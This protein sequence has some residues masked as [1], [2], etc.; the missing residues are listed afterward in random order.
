MTKAPNKRLK[1]HESKLH[2]DKRFKRQHRL[3]DVFVALA[4]AHDAKETYFWNLMGDPRHEE[5]EVWRAIGM[6]SAEK[7]MEVLQ[8]AGW[9]KST[10]EWNPRAF[11]ASLRKHQYCKTGRMLPFRISREFCS[12]TYYLQMGN[13]RSTCSTVQMIKDPSSRSIAYNAVKLFRK[14]M[15]HVKT[16]GFQRKCDI[17]WRTPTVASVARNVSSQTPTGRKRRFADDDWIASVVSSAADFTPKRHE[18]NRSGA[19][20]PSASDGEGRTSEESTGGSSNA[21]DEICAGSGNEHDNILTGDSIRTQSPAFGDQPPQ[22]ATGTQAPRESWDVRIQAAIKVLGANEF[23]NSSFAST[24]AYCFGTSRPPRTTVPPGYCIAHLVD[25]AASE[26]DTLYFLTKKGCTVQWT[27]VG[28]VKHIATVN[29]V[30]RLVNASKDTLLRKELDAAKLQLAGLKDIAGRQKKYTKL[31]DYSRIII[32]AMVCYHWKTSSLTWEQAFPFIAK[33][34]LRHLGLE[35]NFVDIVNGCAPN[36]QAFD[37]YVE[38]LAA[39]TNVIISESIERAGYYCLGF[40]KADLKKGGIGGCSKIICWFATDFANADHPDGQIMTAIIDGDKTGNSSEEVADGVEF[41]V[42]K[43]DLSRA[44]GAGICT[45]SGGGGTL[46][47][48]ATPLKRKGILEDWASVANCG[49]HNI[50]LISGR[51]IG[52]SIADKSNRNTGSLHGLQLLYA[53]CAW[54]KTVGRDEC[55]KMFKLLVDGLIEDLDRTGMVGGEDNDEEGDE[56]R[57]QKVAETVAGE[58]MHLT[59]DELEGLQFKTAQKGSETR[60]W[61]IGIAAKVMWEQRHVFRSLIIT[62]ANIKGKKNGVTD[63]AK[64]CGN[65]FLSLSDEPVVVSDVALIADFQ[66]VFMTPYTRWIQEED[67]L[68]RKS[69]FQS[70]NTLVSCFLMEKDLN[71]FQGGA[72]KTHHGF[73]RF[74][75]SLGQITNAADKDFQVSKYVEFMKIALLEFHKMFALWMDGPLVYRGVFAELPTARIVAQR[76]L[77]MP[78]C[79]DPSRTWL[80]FDCWNNKWINKGENQLKFLQAICRRLV[81]F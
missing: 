68:A 43:L 60:W 44:Q 10:G 28:G 15:Q 61:S 58:L 9:V 35:A 37:Q 42:K 72:Y 75:E 79:A 80:G 8:A 22:P 1:N 59:K 29:K 53:A 21:T 12:R 81:D 6:S 40:D 71:A 23:G 19:T 18:P 26:D 45:D 20:S 17:L 77:S 56:D 7:W 52:G 4:K 13:L 41:S 46:H 2:L 50:S 33:I 62:Y 24:Q 65:T 64:K 70:F 27:T 47:S 48:V 73:D 66:D 57:V 25:K 51:A 36:R 32:G 31:D 3:I 54:M 38:E 67:K 63:E 69:G 39:H 78:P 34:A 16:N 5:A 30:D 11:N 74:R 49:L 55:K 14:R 76:M